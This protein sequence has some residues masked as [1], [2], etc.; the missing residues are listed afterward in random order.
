MEDNYKYLQK[1][2]GIFL[3]CLIIILASFNFTIQL[4]NAQDSGNL[5]C[6]DCHSR[7]IER[8]RF[9]NNPCTSCHSQDM[10]TIT[11]RN[12]KIIPL[13]ESTSLCAQCH[14]TIYD[15]WMEG[16]HGRI[17]FKCVE[18][19]DPHFEV[20]KSFTSTLKAASFS[21]FFQIIT[22]AGGVIGILLAVLATIKVK[23]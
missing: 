16:K 12:G 5:E 3:I 10:S 4:S 7:V 13:E 6:S 21:Q 17:E 19:H 18:C 8:H 22:A 11:L 23:K 9:P 2:Y 1:N 14:N 20:T 15:S